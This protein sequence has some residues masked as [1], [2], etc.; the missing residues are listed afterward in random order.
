[1]FQLIDFRPVPAPR[2]RLAPAAVR[3]SGQPTPLA[4]KVYLICDTPGF[5]ACILASMV[6]KVWLKVSSNLA[7]EESWEL[8]I[9]RR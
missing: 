4:V 3:T 6:S 1:M 9:F 7:R 2:Q 8:G 5:G